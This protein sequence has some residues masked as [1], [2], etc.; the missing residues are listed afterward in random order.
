MVILSFILLL[1]GILVAYEVRWRDQIKK[2]W[3]RGT[4]AVI[5]A[6]IIAPAVFSFLS[7]WF[8]HADKEKEIAIPKRNI[9]IY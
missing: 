6:T 2:R 4:I 3:L 1:L 9:D 8:S 5:L 7:E